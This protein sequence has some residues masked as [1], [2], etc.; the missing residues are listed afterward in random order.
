ML[1]GCLFPLF[2]LPIT[3]SAEVAGVVEVEDKVHN[4]QLHTGISELEARCHPLLIV[5]S[6]ICLQLEGGKFASMKAIHP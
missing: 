1:A 6:L 5:G 2:H 4:S 3:L